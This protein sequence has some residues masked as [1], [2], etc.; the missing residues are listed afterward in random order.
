MKES[1]CLL[2]D[3]LCLASSTCGLH[4]FLPP[5]RL[6]ADDTNN[7]SL[8]IKERVW[9]GWETSPAAGAGLCTLTG[10]KEDGYVW[11]LAG[12]GAQRGRVEQAL[13]RKLLNVS[14]LGN[15]MGLSTP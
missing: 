6:H 11:C 3:V 7:R 2:P 8:V 15:G 1:S 12:C 10:K 5:A 9:E 4:Y 14:Q 13:R